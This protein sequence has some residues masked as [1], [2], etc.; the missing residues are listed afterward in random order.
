MKFHQAALHSVFSGAQ[1][2]NGKQIY[3]GVEIIIKLLKTYLHSQT[4]ELQV[5]S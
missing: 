3:L 5:S 4:T 1:G 2:N